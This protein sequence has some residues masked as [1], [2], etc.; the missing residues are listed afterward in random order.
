MIRF[1]NA[2]DFVAEL[3]EIKRCGAIAANVIRI[4]I[5]P[6]GVVVIA[7]ARVSQQYLDGRGSDYYP[8]YEILRLDWKIGQPSEDGIDAPT[9]AASQV[10]KAEAQK[11]GMVVRPGIIE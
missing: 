4:A 2:D 8:D 3:A 7:T 5:D 11:L 9:Q 10:L 1:T 6:A